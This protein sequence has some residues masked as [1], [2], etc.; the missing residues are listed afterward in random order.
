MTEANALLFPLVY[1]PRCFSCS[2]PHSSTGSVAGL[3]IV[4]GKLYIV[5]VLT[6]R[7]KRTV[8]AHAL[9]SVGESS[10]IQGAG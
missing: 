6:R 5:V 8:L 4:N 7:G 9:H 1:N 2:E 3:Y 10:R